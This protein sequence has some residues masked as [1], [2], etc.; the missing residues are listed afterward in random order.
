[1]MMYLTISSNNVSVHTCDIR[2]CHPQDITIYKCSSTPFYT[3]VSLVKAGRRNSARQTHNMPHIHIFLHI[4][5]I[6]CMLH[7]GKRL[8]PHTSWGL[9]NHYVGGD[10]GPEGRF[11]TNEVLIWIKSSK[12]AAKLSRGKSEVL[13]ARRIDFIHQH[14]ELI[15]SWALPSKSKLLHTVLLRRGIHNSFTW[16]CEAILWCLKVP[17]RLG[18]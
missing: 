3:V 10:D 13:P 4:M 1:M 5:E 14:L 2:Y 17:Q 15:N 11:M 8:W 18:E 6:S 7:I 16:F 12:P 9:S